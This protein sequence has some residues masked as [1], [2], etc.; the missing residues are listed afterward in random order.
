[1]KILNAYLFELKFNCLIFKNI[2][3]ILS[4]IIL[5]VVLKKFYFENVTKFFAKKILNFHN[6][7]IWNKTLFN[8]QYYKI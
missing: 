7:Q 3:K 1:M 2:N 6:I 4:D 5:F 8:N